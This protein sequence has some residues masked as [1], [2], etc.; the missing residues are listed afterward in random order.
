[1]DLVAIKYLYEYLN[2][3]RLWIMFNHTKSTEQNHTLEANSRSAAPEIA[4]L[5]E[6]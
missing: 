1:M 5:S 3:S 2:L 6:M 4:L